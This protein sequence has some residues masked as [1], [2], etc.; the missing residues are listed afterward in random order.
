MSRLASQATPRPRVDCH[1]W[2]AKQARDCGLIVI[3]CSRH[4]ASCHRCSRHP[5]NCQCH[6]CSRHATRHRCSKHSA[7]CHRHPRQSAPVITG[8]MTPI[9]PTAPTFPTLTLFR[10]PSSFFCLPFPSFAGALC[11]TLLVIAPKKHHQRHVTTALEVLAVWVEHLEA[12]EL[13]PARRH[14]RPRP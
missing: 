9:I 3:D 14:G 4:P 13:L 7:S 1:D 11:P 5:A 2:P 8:V 6:R 12:N 10:P